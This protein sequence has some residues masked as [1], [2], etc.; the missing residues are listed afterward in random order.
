MAELCGSGP[1][2]RTDTKASTADLESHPTRPNNTIRWP[3]SCPYYNA[4][5]T[6]CWRARDLLY[7]DA[8]YLA[9]TEDD[10]EHIRCITLADGVPTYG[11]VK[12]LGK[13]LSPTI[14]S[15]VPNAKKSAKILFVKQKRRY[16]SD[17]RNSLCQIVLRFS[18][19]EEVLHNF[20]VPPKF[21][22][23][24]HSN[25]GGFGA[26]ISYC[27]D[28][29]T[30]SQHQDCSKN[31]TSAFHLYLKIGHWV[32]NEHAVYAR[33]DF[34][35]G[36]DLVLVMGTAAREYSARILAHLRASQ[37]HLG[38][39]QILLCLSSYWLEQVEELRT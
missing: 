11:E 20:C 9:P 15:T 4:D 19:W 25:N 1:S 21:L 39:P 36:H 13:D 38:L 34:H 7:N 31:G 10:L 37:N 32:N 3:E 30:N 29:S 5:I 28:D 22:E 17:S 24:L 8:V 33:H 14:P 23:I 26:E 12:A 6:D 16:Y 35:T 27:N 18:T 2:E